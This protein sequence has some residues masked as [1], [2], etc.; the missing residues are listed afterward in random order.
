MAGSHDTR[1]QAVEKTDILIIGGG[2]SGCVLAARLSEDGSR[3]V[4]LVESGPDIAEGAIPAAI[5]SP[6][7]SRAFFSREY[8]YENLTAHLGQTLADGVTRPAPR[9]EQARV[10]GGGSSINGMCGNR[11]AP[12]DY[13][14]WAASG[15]EG[16]G[17]DDVL[18]YF[19]KLERD[20]DFSGP[21]HGQDGPIPISRIPAEKRSGFSKEVVKALASRGVKVLDDQNGFWE[22]GVTRVALT[23]D[24]AGHRAPTS[25]TYLSA[26]VR[27]RPNLRIHTDTTA[28]RLRLSG[29]TVVGADFE[30]QGR[31]FSIMA[32][33]TI[34][35][36]GAI[37]TPV[38][39]MR[40]GIGPAADLQRLGV[41]V[42]ADLLGVGRHLLEHPA[43]GL[44]CFLER[45]ARQGTEELHHNQAHWR[46]SSGLDGIPAGD[47]NVAVL[48]RSA[49]H[50]IGEQIATFYLFV[51]KSYSEGSVTLRSADPTAAP[52]IDFRLLSDPRDRQR[53][54][55]MFREVAAFALSSELDGVRGEVFPTVFSDRVRAVSRPGLWNAVQ[56]S[57]FA[58][59]LDAVGPGLRRLLIRRFIA[60]T[61]IHDLLAD[62]TALDDFV[63]K[64]VVGVWHACGTCKMGG[65]DDPLAVTDTRGVVRGVDG[66]RIGDASLMP[67]IPCANTNLPTIMVAERIADFMKQGRRRI[68]TVQAAPSEPGN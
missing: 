41:P 6:Y 23:A 40:S 19:R 12:T 55:S 18:P 36:A 42:V 51:N 4:T 13:D 33:E 25:T 65:P 66:L 45:S 47:L 17:W 20:L 35:C 16:W 2:S 27:S 14:E 5:R 37:H 21:Y 1:H 50:A 54:V 64:A 62:D 48:A 63:D 61:D 3:R 32:P 24:E 39:L 59:M 68:E 31:R 67:T 30:S 22:D 57:I 49:W 15:A 26:K 34:V 9:F 8:F 11:G 7:P 10:L 60:P 29:R 53:M 43:L 58:R 56:T 44:S 52:L 46:L 28:T 38:L